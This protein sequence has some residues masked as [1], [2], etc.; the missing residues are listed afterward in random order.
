MQGRW[1]L[2]QSYLNFFS[3]LGVFS[4]FTSLVAI[5]TALV[6][7]LFLGVFLVFGGWVMLKKEALYKSHQTSTYIEGRLVLLLC[8]MKWGKIVQGCSSKLPTQ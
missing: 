3:F 8:S 7:L 2:S 6:F 1:H 4:A 5:H